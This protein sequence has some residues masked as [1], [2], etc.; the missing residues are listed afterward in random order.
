[1]KVRVRTTARKRNR[2]G[3]RYRSKTRHGRKLIRNRRRMGRALPGAK[4]TR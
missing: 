4:K 3:F 2:R 1:M